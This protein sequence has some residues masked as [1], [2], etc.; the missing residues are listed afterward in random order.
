MSELNRLI[1]L[2]AGASVD[3]GVYPTGSEIIEF[4]KKIIQWSEGS[5]AKKE[6]S[7]SFEEKSLD[8]TSKHAQE[9]QV[10]AEEAPKEISITK[11]QLSHLKNLI[12][13]NHASID[14][15][16]SSIGDEEEQKFLKSFYLATFLFCTACSE[17]TEMFENNWYIELTKLVIP[18]LSSKLDNKSRLE[19]VKEKLKNLQV[20]TF[21]YDISLEIFLRKALERFFKESNENYRTSLEN[22]FKEVCKKIFH[23]YGA[24][25]TVDEILEIDCAKLSSKE[26]SEVISKS[27]DYESAKNPKSFVEY[28]L[29]VKAGFLAG[30]SFDNLN[31]FK[32]FRSIISPN[33]DDLSENENILHTYSKQ[34]FCLI[35]GVVEE[36]KDIEDPKL[37][38]SSR[39]KVI[40]EERANL[41][42][43][44]PLRVF[45]QKP[46]LL[47]VLG[48]GFDETNN[49]I[50][51]LEE[52]KYQKGCFVTN[53]GK[54]QKL[55]RLILDDLLSQK[56]GRTHNNTGPMEY[57][58]P[59][60]SHKSVS[61]ALKKD[62]S[63]L[64]SP[65]SPLKIQ[66]NLTP[67]LEMKK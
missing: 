43:E 42:E 64:E 6:Q 44:I 39:I 4:V 5:I 41:E 48:Y 31:I 19:A 30:G 27:D 45:K 10:H 36:I 58:I 26:V 56:L 18:T 51:R 49:K 17:T 1:I 61:A 67:Y 3:C 33:R 7:V 13:S 24:I 14:A 15:H 47:Y 11:K 16:I 34:V 25:A 28:L 35:L 66:T 55:Q 60:I 38:S 59:L 21:N 62:F 23:V 20:I 2:G 50:L 40:S 53:L 65:L 8:L 52:I 54:N 37:F 57:F 29:Q 9:E 22:A 12:A 46:D 63:L 32:G